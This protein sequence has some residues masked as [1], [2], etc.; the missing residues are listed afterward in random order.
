MA[1]NSIHWSFKHC[2]TLKDRIRDK[3]QYLIISVSNSVL[4]SYFNLLYADKQ[5]HLVLN[6]IKA[7]MS[8]DR[9]NK[10]KQNAS[11]TVFFCIISIIFCQQ[12]RG[13][14]L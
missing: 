1:T 11:Y 10:G 12:I 2:Y 8:F 6:Y 3:L 4:T 14:L 5:F 13:K 7:A 9:L